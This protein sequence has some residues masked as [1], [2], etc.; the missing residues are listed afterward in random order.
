MEATIETEMFDD[1]VYLKPHPS[2]QRILN[3]DHFV[4]LFRMKEEDGPVTSAGAMSKTGDLESN[5]AVSTLR[6]AGAAL[7]MGM[8]NNR[9]QSGLNISDQ[10]S[11]AMDM[12]VISSRLG[13]S[14]L[15]KVQQ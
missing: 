10:G 6:R 14:A 7:I 3:Q 2:R 15:R 9:K 13:D 1:H 4:S 11:S 5:T 12:N 8:A